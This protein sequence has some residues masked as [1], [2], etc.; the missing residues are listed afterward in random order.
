MDAVEYTWRK[1]YCV[2]FVHRPTAIESTCALNMQSAVLTSNNTRPGKYKIQ[3]A[4][5]KN[6]TW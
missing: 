3:T 5:G 1:Y 6:N 4:G 2:C